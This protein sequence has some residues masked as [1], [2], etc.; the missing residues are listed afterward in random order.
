MYRGNEKG[1]FLV[2]E[3]ADF[4]TSINPPVQNKWKTRKSGQNL[5]NA[6]R[7]C[8]ANK[9]MKIHENEMRYSFSY[10]FQV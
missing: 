9:A 2:L 8:T 7:K 6:W 5:N 3:M 1:K 10:T 4:L